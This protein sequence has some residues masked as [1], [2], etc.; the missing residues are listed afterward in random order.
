MVADGSN[1]LAVV[2]V[3]IFGLGLPALVALKAREK[4]RRFGVWFI[5]ALFLFLPALI[6]V[7][8]IKPEKRCPQCAEQIPKA[9]RICPHCGTD[10]SRFPSRN[11]RSPRHVG[12][13]F[14]SKTVDS[15]DVSPKSS[16]SSGRGGRY[17]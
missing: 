11:R 1:G 17:V 3:L 2:A 16:T 4:G 6:A 10:Q 7:F 13:G 15:Y 5:F 12:G 9:A 14:L 8:V